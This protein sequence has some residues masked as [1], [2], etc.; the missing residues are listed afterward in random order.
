MP[1]NKFRMKLKWC[2]EFKFEVLQPYDLGSGQLTGRRQHSPITIVREVDKASPLLWQALCSN[3]SFESASLQ[4]VRPD[5]NGKET[6]YYTITLTNATIGGY[7]TYHGKGGK[8][9]ETV[10]LVFD[11]LEVNGVRNGIIPYFVYG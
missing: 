3:E 9:R 8:K 6:V 1:G 10:T 4:F 7:R 2:L 5:S 11:D